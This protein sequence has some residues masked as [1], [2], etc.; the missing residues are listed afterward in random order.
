MPR[1]KVPCSRLVS[2]QLLD[3]ELQTHKRMYV[4][5]FMTSVLLSNCHDGWFEMRPYGIERR[6]N[7][8]LENGGRLLYFCFLHLHAFQSVARSR[9][10]FFT[11]FYHVRSPLPR[12][13]GLCRRLCS[14]TASDQQP[15]PNLLV[16]YVSKS[17]FYTLSSHILFFISRGLYKHTPVEL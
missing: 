11:L 9:T 3:M 6:M 13:R 15:Q 10:T 12:R 14:C 1:L 17:H 16:G 2:D 7:W 4:L 8:V 5:L